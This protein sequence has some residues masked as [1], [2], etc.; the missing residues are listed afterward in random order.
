MIDEDSYE[1]RPVYLDFGSMLA[2]LPESMVLVA[3]RSLVHVGERGIIL[4]GHAELSM[5]LLLRA[6]NDKEV[7]A[8]AKERVLFVE[9]VSHENLFPRLKCTVHHGKYFVRLRAQWKIMIHHGS[10]TTNILHPVLLFHF[11]KIQ[12][13]AG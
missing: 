3:V 13:G 11:H 9:N 1:R 2:I 12:E 7:I 4:G 8:Y 10:V 5:E 6:T